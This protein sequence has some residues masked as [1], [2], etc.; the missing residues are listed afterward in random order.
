M[1][2]R[3]EKAAGV[4]SDSPD[5]VRQHFCLIP[6]LSGHDAGGHDTFRILQKEDAFSVTSPARAGRAPCIHSGAEAY[7]TT[8]LTSFPGTTITLRTVFPAM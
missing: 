1:Q 5:K 8:T 6:R 2:S 4:S 7:P 3:P